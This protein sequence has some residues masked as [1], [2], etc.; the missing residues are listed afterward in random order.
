[1]AGKTRGYKNMVILGEGHRCV[2][3]NFYNRGKKGKLL[4]IKQ[5]K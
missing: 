1:M 3:L 5:N 2:L 4:A